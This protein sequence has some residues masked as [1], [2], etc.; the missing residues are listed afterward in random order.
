MGQR[1][2]G[3]FVSVIIAQERAAL[4]VALEKGV[5]TFEDP[6]QGSAREAD[7]VLIAVQPSRRRKNLEGMA[8]ALVQDA[9]NQLRS[10]D[11]YAQAIPHLLSGDEM[12]PL[13][14]SSL[15]RSIHEAA[16]GLAM[17]FDPSLTP[18]QRI[19][20]MGAFQLENAQGALNALATFGL[21]YR[22][23][24]KE[25]FEKLALRHA[26]MKKAGFEI[27]PKRGKAPL[28]DAVTWGASKASLKQNVTAASELYTPKTHY[29][30]V[31]GSGATHCRLW[32]SDGLSGDWETI[33]VGAVAPLLDVADLIVDKLLGYLGVDGQLLHENTHRRRRALL[34]RVL[35]GD[36]QSSYEEYLMA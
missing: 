21:Q 13:P 27:H 9:Y 5:R 30:W 6:V 24:E 7:R 31:L 19:A 12:L 1:T 32:Y 10:I 3:E 4:S 18:E 22:D 25:L 29:S 36:P 14:I 23:E 28:A 33:V 8:T 2:I 20:R 34:G 35:S 26:Y 17:L 15:G 11:Q 16:L